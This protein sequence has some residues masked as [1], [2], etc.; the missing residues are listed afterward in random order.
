MKKM[1][2][3]NNKTTRNNNKKPQ[4]KFKNNKLT[5]LSVTHQF[6]E[7]NPMMKIY[8][9]QDH[10]RKRSQNYKLSKVWHYN[11]WYKNLAK[12]YYHCQWNYKIIGIG[13]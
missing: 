1:F 6:K 11:K 9:P 12:I 13:V 3:K 4:H 5:Y 10:Y 2:T 8:N 7:L